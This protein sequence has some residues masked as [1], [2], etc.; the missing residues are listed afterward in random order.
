MDTETRDWAQ[1]ARL[2]L[3]HSQSTSARTLFLRHA[4]GSV[5]A[6]TPLPPLSTLLDDG[7]GEAGLFLH[8]AALIRDYCLKMELPTDLLQAQGEFH[9]RVETPQR[10]VSVYL[11][12]FTCIDPPRE[13]FAE[14]GGKF[15]AITELRGGHPAEMGLLQRAYQTIMG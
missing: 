13:L 4:S 15:C 5:I 12:R 6:P 1:A 3:Y 10:I 11:A 9:G 2:I 7:D 8:P 14:G